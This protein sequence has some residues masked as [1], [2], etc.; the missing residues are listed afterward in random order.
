M[1]TV[2]DYSVNN[3]NLFMII[4]NKSYFIG[5]VKGNVYLYFLPSSILFITYNALLITYPLSTRLSLSL[6]L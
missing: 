4:V 3:A 5:A 2:I 6:A 1:A